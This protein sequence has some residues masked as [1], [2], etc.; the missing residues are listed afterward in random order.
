[1]Q[2]LSNPVT[3]QN[4]N[5]HV[6]YTRPNAERKVA[7]QITNMGI[8]SYL[9]LYKVV[10]QWSD[11]KK[12]LEL[13]LFPNYVFIRVD[14]VKRFDI[15]SIKEIVKFVTFESRPAVVPEAQLN[16]IKHLIER[17]EDMQSAN[18]FE[19]GMKI[20]IKEGSFAG[21]EGVIVKKNNM[22]RLL[23]KVEPMMQAFSINISS[24]FLK[25]LKSDHTSLVEE[26]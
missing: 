8:E 24:H 15:F 26:M 6:V 12:K 1:M 11:R 20:K 7:S 21:L 5:W 3:S 23:I 17:G 18:F 22:L 16:K 13:P 9:P 19:D 2:Q 25:Y 4:L 14:K 10:K